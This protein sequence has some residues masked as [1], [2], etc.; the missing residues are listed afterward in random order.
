MALSVAAL[1]WFPNPSL[2]AGQVKLQLFNSAYDIEN[3]G[4]NFGYAGQLGAV[5]VNDFKAVENCE[6]YFD[7]DRLVDGE[8]LLELMTDVEVGVT[9]ANDIDLFV[10]DFGKINGLSKQ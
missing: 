8:D 5:G 7:G 10:S 2:T 6:N 9:G 3:L 1:I 4:C